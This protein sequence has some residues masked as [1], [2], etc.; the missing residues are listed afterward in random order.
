[1]GLFSW[2]F[3]RLLRRDRAVP[4][5]GPGDKAFLVGINA[6]PSS[7]LRG[8]VND[9]HSFKALLL[10][11]YG[12]KEANIRILLNSDATTKNMTDGLY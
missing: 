12:F 5:G 8:C 3:N 11:K 1:M 10:Q 9:V 7:P 6:Y 4:G 2:F